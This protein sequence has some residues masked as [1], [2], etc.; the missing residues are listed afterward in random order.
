[1]ALKVHKPTSAGRR[2]SSVN[3]REELTGAKPT[4]SLLRPLRKKAGA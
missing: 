2:N 4:K 3:V 1:M